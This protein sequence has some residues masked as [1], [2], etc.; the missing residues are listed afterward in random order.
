[1]QKVIRQICILFVLAIIGSGLASTT[2]ASPAH[3]H[4][5]HHAIASP[6]HVKAKENTASLFASWS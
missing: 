5:N 2:L 6:F 3:D 1:M 4:H